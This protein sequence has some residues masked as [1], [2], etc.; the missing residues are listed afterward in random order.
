MI[1]ADDITQMTADVAEIR[2]D[3]PVSIVLRRGST[4]LAAQTVRV[5]LTGSATDRVQESDAA[6]ESRG[7]VVVIGPTTFNVQPGD[8]FN[9]AAGVL[10]EVTFVHPNRLAAIRAEARAVE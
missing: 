7:Q 3:N 6:Q 1:N 4:T 8:R 2:A 9:D 10:Y 5:V